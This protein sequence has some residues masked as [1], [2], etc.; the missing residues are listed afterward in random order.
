MLKAEAIVYPK[1]G[2]VLSGISMSVDKGEAVCILGD[3]GSGK[4]LLLEILSTLRRPFAGILTIM[5]KDAIKNPDNIRRHIGYVPDDTHFIEGYSVEG[6]LAAFGG[7]YGLKGA[8][9]NIRREEVI[10]IMG[11]EDFKNLPMVRL[12]QSVLKRV[13]FA[14]SLIHQPG[15]LIIDNPF[16]GIDDKWTTRLSG[17]LISLRK[18]GTTIIC[19]TPS[20]APVEGAR[21]LWNRVEKLENGVLRPYE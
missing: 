7:C 1:G 20:L 2:G 5:G 19:G 8:R 11:L 13:S 4:T 15:V 3:N 14:R 18:E 12:S 10:R 21:S 17:I 16:M 9:N 6:Y